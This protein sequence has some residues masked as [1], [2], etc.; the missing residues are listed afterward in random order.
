MF[1]RYKGGIELPQNYGGS[2][3][4]RVEDGTETKTHRGQITPITTPSVKSSSSQSFQSVIDKVVEDSLPIDSPKTEGEA[5]EESESSPVFTVEESE[6]SSVD[7][8]EKEENSENDTPLTEG[9][10][11]DFKLGSIGKLLS[12][13]SQEDLLLLVLL[14]LFASDGNENS[15][16]VV[17]ILALLLLYHK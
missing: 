11:S 15:F 10:L 14:L 17:T 12:N 9:F 16:D 3:F 7:T 4:K 6:L 2:R 8:E 5:V 1:T 13:I